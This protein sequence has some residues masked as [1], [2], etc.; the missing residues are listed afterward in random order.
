[1]DPKNLNPSKKEWIGLYVPQ[2]NAK[3]ILQGI[4]NNSLPLL[5]KENG[6]IDVTPIFNANTGY[7]L[8]AKD[9]IPAQIVKANNGYESNIVGTKNTVDKAGTQIKEGE[10]GLWYNWQDK[11]K[12]FHHSALFFAEQM[13]DPEKFVENVQIKQPQRLQNVT[14]KINTPEAYLPMYLAAAKSGAKLEVSPEVA[15]EFTN[16]LKDICV[17]EKTNLHDVLFAA[18]LEANKIVKATEQKRGVAPTYA[19]ET[20]IEKSMSR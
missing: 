16:Q 13:T 2:H 12:Q 20:K 7:I 4:E 19:R 6:R 17:K 11:D 14:F 8:A 10:K 15:K 9:L 18:D 5:P 1:M 3:L